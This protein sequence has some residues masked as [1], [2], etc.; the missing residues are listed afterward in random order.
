MSGTNER[1]NREK[2]QMSKMKFGDPPARR[3]TAYDWHEIAAQLKARPGEWA[4]VFTQ[5]RYSLVAAIT[6]NNISA[7]ADDGGTF[8]VRTTNNKYVEEDDGVVRR[9]CDLWLRFVPS[10]PKRKRK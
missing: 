3:T 8:E 10:T 2:E 5:D 4:E 6:A 9:L 7:F 1:T